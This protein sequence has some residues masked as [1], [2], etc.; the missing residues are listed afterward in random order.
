[1]I[2]V[3]TSKLLNYSSHVYDWLNK[4][5]IG[6]CILIALI[7][8]IIFRWFY[9]IDKYSVNILFWD[10][11]DFYN[12]FFNEKSLIEIFRWQHGPHRQGIA[13]I[14]T[15]YIDQLSGWN[16][17][18]ICFAI[19]ILIF[20]SS[21]I[22]LK[23]KKNLFANL[24]FIDGI[25]FFII[26]TPL[27]YGVFTNTPNLSHGAMPAFLLSIYCLT[28]F[29]KSFYLRYTALL[30][31]N[32]LMIFSGFG[33]FIGLL[34]PLLLILDIF[35]EKGN[36]KNQMLLA[37]ILLL[38]I[39]SFYSFFV[40][41]HFASANPNFKFPHDKPF[42]YIQFIILSLG[43]ILNLKFAGG[44]IITLL[45]IYVLIKHFI[46]LVK[47]QVNDNSILLS[48]IIVVLASY[49][50]LFIINT[51]VGRVSFGVEAGKASRYIP[52]LVPFIYA[53]YLHLNSLNTEYKKAYSLVLFLTCIYATTFIRSDVKE[54][55]RF[56][57]GKEAWKRNY[58]HTGKITRADKLS[59]FKIYPN[60]KATKLS[61]KLNFLKRR[62][63]NLFHD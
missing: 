1:M 48:K 55:K 3:I 33:I 15:K 11:W 34:T 2:T 46:I 53:I 13:F 47:N 37:I 57:D 60:P 6:I 30:I 28:L 61:K 62:K 4:N 54:M 32:F 22:Y 16:V 36:I 43:N 10:Q 39:L 41:Y 26:L 25:I 59:D 40:D 44:V 8:S 9:Y 18:W 52:Y 20:A 49:S 23:V 5:K 31:V 12:A 19:G 27:Q 14:L 17:R 45:S 50:F 24:N 21:L 58:L 42:E 56:R 29:I 7:V 63:L 51:A 38:S 35:K